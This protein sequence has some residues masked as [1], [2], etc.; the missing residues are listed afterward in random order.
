MNDMKKIYLMMVMA[1]VA[2]GG[3]AY[4][5]PL[6]DFRL[7]T[8][9]TP[10]YVLSSWHRINAY[11][12][13]IRIYIEGDDASSTEQGFPT[14]N[15]TPT[16]D[17]FRTIASEDSAQNVAYLA[18]PCQY[19]QAGSCSSE[20][21][22]SGRFSKQ[23]VDSMTQAVLNLMKKAGAKKATLIGY[24]GGAQLAGLIALKEPGKIVEVITLAGVWDYQKWAEYHGFPAF[25]DSISLTEWR[26][27]KDTIKQT[28][29]VGE[30]DTVVPPELAQKWASNVVVVKGATHDKGYKK[31]YSKLYGEKE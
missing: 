26:K 16:S 23:S 5:N 10:P 20:T 13:P 22:G 11:G 3:C 18:Q 17:F 19:L 15:P 30:K 29:F 1:L 14:T 9:M 4:H 7:Q 8:Q 2:L 6:E 28:H 31:I 27:K 12:E 25:K 24:G 21:W